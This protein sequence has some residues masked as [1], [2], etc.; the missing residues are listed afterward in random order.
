MLY[1]KICQQALNNNNDKVLLVYI[2]NAIYLYYR[3]IKKLLSNY[4]KIYR[5]YENFLA[6]KNTRIYQ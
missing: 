2:L 1:H 5:A 3:Q 4:N 6:I